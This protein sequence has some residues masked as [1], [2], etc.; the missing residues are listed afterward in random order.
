MLEPRK[1]YKECYQNDPAETNEV[2]NVAT[3]RILF[4]PVAKV[5]D[6]AIV[7][8]RVLSTAATKAI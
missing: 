7:I 1:T 6:I 2:D 8:R 4:D 5:V 3:S